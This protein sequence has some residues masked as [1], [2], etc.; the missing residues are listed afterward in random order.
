VAGA[1]FNED[2]N[3]CEGWPWTEL[4]LDTVCAR[5]AF[6]LCQN[7]IDCCDNAGV[8]DVFGVDLEV[9]LTHCVANQL[10]FCEQSALARDRYLASQDPPQVESVPEGLAAFDEQFADLGCVRD[11]NWLGWDPELVAGLVRGVVT[12]GNV[13]LEDRACAEADDYCWWGRQPVSHAWAFDDDADASSAFDN[14]TDDANDAD[15]GGDVT[16]FTNEDDATDDA[17]YFGASFLFQAVYLDVETAGSDTFDVDWEYYNGVDEEWTSLGTLFD[18]Q[19]DGFTE[20]YLEEVPEDWGTF[21]VNGVG[22]YYWLRALVTSGAPDDDVEGN[23]VW[24][25]ETVKRCTQRGA[26]D[27]ACRTDTGLEVPQRTCLEGLEC[28]LT[29]QG[30]TGYTCEDITRLLGGACPAEGGYSPLVET[31]DIVWC[32][33]GELVCRPTEDPAD[34][35]QAWVI[36]DPA[37]TPSYV[38]VTGDFSD[39]GSGDVNPW[40]A[41]EAVGDQ[42]AIGFEHPFNQIT[43]TVDTAGVGGTL[44]VKYWNGSAWVGLPILSDQT[45]DFLIAGTGDLSWDIPEDWEPQEI[46]GSDELYYIVF[47]VNSVYATTNPVLGEGHVRVTFCRNHIAEDAECP[48]R[49]GVSGVDW[50]EAGTY[51]EDGDG[52]PDTCQPKLARGDAC[53]IEFERS[54][55]RGSFA[56]RSEHTACE[57][58]LRCTIVEVDTDTYETQCQPAEDICLFLLEACELEELA[59]IGSCDNGE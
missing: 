46:N 57:D 38:D 24:L 19:T 23:Q 32:G 7:F 20:I 55:G 44:D 9:D 2:L 27:E 56:M 58:D 43:I 59:G 25:I 51:C 28:T 45:N 17:F 47:E 3:E 1:I 14:E 34:L 30:E 48:R 22:P 35:D 8:R 31:G 33:G 12:E 53:D 15:S 4:T 16:F 36:D 18:F 50:C 5:R 40:P 6:A 21:E 42:F 29:K 26:E 41:D 11:V 10:N 49:E 54:L 13:C 37:G 39:S 52:D